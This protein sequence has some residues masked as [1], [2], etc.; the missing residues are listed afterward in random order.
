MADI[1]STILT[2]GG[3]TVKS[4]TPEYVKFHDDKVQHLQLADA[5]P[6]R[7]SQFLTGSMLMILKM[8][9]MGMKNDQAQTIF[10]KIL[11]C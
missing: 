8:E 5:F 3:P 6:I 9:A 7:S 4:T 11:L 1:V 2:A 10:L